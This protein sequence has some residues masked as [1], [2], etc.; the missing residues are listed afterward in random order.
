MF[1]LPQKAL[2]EKQG[3]KCGEDLE[4]AKK[5]KRINYWITYRLPRGKQKFEKITGENANSIEY[6]RDADGKRRIQKRE[7]RIFDIK[8]ESKM[9]FEE[10]TKW[11]LDLQKVKALAPYPTLP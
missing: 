3:C 5:G 6:A 2:F 8:P 9:T 4:K 7:N 1:A 10:L 11:Y